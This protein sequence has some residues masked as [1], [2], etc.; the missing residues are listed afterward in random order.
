MAEKLK[1]DDGI[2]ELEI[3][4]NGL[5]RFNPAD[6]NVYQR[7]CELLRE[8]PELEKKYAAEVE[9]SGVQPSNPD[10]LSPSEVVELVGEDL[11]NAKEIDAEVKKK[12][13]WAFGPG[14]DFDQLLGGV[15]VM[16]PGRNG[17][18]TIT[19]FL[20]AVKPYFEDGMKRH[21]QDAAANAVGEAK[22]KR[23]KRAMQ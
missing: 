23:A 10:E 12:L 11:D 13:A 17:E 19:N 2:I 5:L 9:A 22:K 14:N 1:F 16:S 6:L 8:L 18:R 21:M 4:D 15:N 3:N 20:Y 7:L